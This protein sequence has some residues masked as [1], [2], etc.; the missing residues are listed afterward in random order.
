MP[1]TMSKLA[2]LLLWR[3]D[4]DAMPPLPRAVPCAGSLTDERN[5]IAADGTLV[6]D[7]MLAIAASRACREHILHTREGHPPPSIE[8]LLSQQLDQLKHTVDAMFACRARRLEIEQMP[9]DEQHAAALQLR[10]Y[11]ERNGMGGGRQQ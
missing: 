2:R 8:K 6:V 7:V 3:D 1:V 10:A 4:D 9:A 11:I 5:L